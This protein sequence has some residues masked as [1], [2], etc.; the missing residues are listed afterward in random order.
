VQLVSSD[1][2]T[3][4][5]KLSFRVSPSSVPLARSWIDHSNRGFDNRE[6]TGVG[7][8]SFQVLRTGDC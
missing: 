1:R 2:Q 3:S 7:Y 6:V 5:S 4:H 8:R